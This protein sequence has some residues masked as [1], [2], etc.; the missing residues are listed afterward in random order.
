M[1]S[2]SSPSSHSSSSFTFPPPCPHLSTYRASLSRPFRHLRRC[3]KI[4]PVGG[5]SVQLDPHSHAV[6]SLCKSSEARLL[7]CL[8][9]ASVFCVVHAGSHLDGAPTHHISVDLDRAELF[10]SSC[11][12][13]VY[14]QD[15]DSAVVVAQSPAFP[16]LNCSVPRSKRRRV[17]FRQWQPDRVQ[18]DLIRSRSTPLSADPSTS[19]SKSVEVDPHPWG[20]RGMNNMGNT[21]F[22]NSVLQALLHAPPFRN[23]FLSDRHNRFLCGKRSRKK[24]G[25]NADTADLCLACDLDEIYSAVFSGERSPFSPAKFLYSWWRH[26]SDL[27]SY[28]QQDAHEFFIS[29]LDRIH[30]NL[31]EDQ[32]KSHNNGQGECCIAHRVFSGILR[33]DVI[34]TQCGFTSTTFD[35]CIDISL[36]LDSSQTLNNNNKNNNHTNNN[37]NKQNQIVSTTL[38]RC[39]EKFT[40]AERLD[41]EQKFYC[42]KCKDKKESLKQMSIKRLP[43]IISFHIKRFEHVKKNLRKVDSCLQF[44]FQLDMSPYLS[45][46]VLRSRY[47]NRLIPPNFDDNNENGIMNNEFEIFAVITHSGRLDAGH[48]VTYLRLDNKWYK[49]DD[50]WI[51]SVDESTVRACQAYML[52]YVQKMIYYRACENNNGMG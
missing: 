33:S 13:Q 39:L 48:Y 35:P 4:R 44:P 46:S 12:D 47:G 36:D 25:G 28:E 41:N 2:S 32:H 51:I 22:M 6:C 31:V 9:C 17:D 14:D 16:S 10:C 26:S 38:M 30:D 52:F 3:L 34:C 24:K 11:S 23:F 20:L 27:A 45:S 1:S 21:C 49:C 15:F 40:R 5:P 19:G 50:A 7:A 8:S 42:Q 43:L 37:N 18:L 29:I